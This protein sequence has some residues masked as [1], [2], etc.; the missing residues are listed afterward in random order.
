MLIVNG[1]KAVEFSD[2]IRLTKGKK[3]DWLPEFWEY[4]MDD[5]SNF[6]LGVRI[7]S[8]PTRGPYVPAQSSIFRVRPQSGG[9]YQYGKPIIQWETLHQCDSVE[10]AWRLF[11]N[12]IRAH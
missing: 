2:V 6:T 3:P 4:L 9:R 1:I 12:A 11:M 7:H 5:E 10:K 8:D